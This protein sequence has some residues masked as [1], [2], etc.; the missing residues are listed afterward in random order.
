MELFWFTSS[1]Q[2]T[3]AHLL[4]IDSVRIFSFSDGIEPVA[5]RTG[6]VV[7]EVLDDSDAAPASDLIEGLNGKVPV[8]IYQQD[9]SVADSVAWMK[10]GVSNFLSSPNALEEALGGISSEPMENQRAVAGLIGRS[11]SIQSVVNSIRLV[12]DRRCNILIEGETGTGKEVVASAIHSTGARS[13]G[14]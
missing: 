3:A 10:A 4:P 6:F 13:R 7:V 2:N 1:P 12:A 14:P 11:Q 5:F 9:G 8:W